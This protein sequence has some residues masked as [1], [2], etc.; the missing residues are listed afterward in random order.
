MLVIAG[1][2]NSGKSEELVKRRKR[3]GFARKEVQAFHPKDVEELKKGKIVSKNGSSFPSE[4]VEKARD[5]LRL[6]KPTTHLVI[7]DEAQ[8]F[9]SEI[10]PVCLE[11]VK[12]RKE[13]LV[14]GL[15]LD[16]RAEPFGSMPLLLTYAH[17][18]VK[19]KAVCQKCGADATRT[20][21]LVDGKPARYDRPVVEI[22][23]SK[24]NLEYPSVCDVC[25]VVPGK[26]EWKP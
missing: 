20:Q 2:M 18:V 14:A 5:I 3:A 12:E 24:E 9:D 4:P 11:L 10:V 25:H 26:P 6:V 7:I 19:L 15:D 13:V 8:F 21:R 16:S 1:C 17:D 23:G 22:E